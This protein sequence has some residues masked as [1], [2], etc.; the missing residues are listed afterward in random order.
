MLK[1]KNLLDDICGNV[2][3]LIQK[4]LN[5]DE[6]NDENVMYVTYILC[7]LISTFIYTAVHENA[8]DKILNLIMKESKTLLE[9]IKDRERM[10]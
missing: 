4:E 10:N 7:K 9:L 2:I 3:T 6:F 5:G 1:D 8:H